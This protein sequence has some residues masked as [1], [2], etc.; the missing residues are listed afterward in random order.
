[1][2]EINP[3][4]SSGESKEVV[5][6]M[7]NNKYPNTDHLQAHSFRYLGNEIK[8]NDGIC[9]QSVRGRRRAI[10]MEESDCLSGV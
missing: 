7:K 10:E 4:P 8:N 1:L 5:N 2:I 9:D 3:P 6:I